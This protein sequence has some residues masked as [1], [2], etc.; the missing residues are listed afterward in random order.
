MEADPLRYE[1]WIE[2]ALRAVIKRALDHAAAHG[3]A[4]EH[5]FYITF[6]T[7]A[8]GLV[9]PGYLRALHPH[10]MTI[11]LQNQ[12]WNLSVTEEGFSVT[13]RFKGRHEKLYIPFDAVTAFADP[14]VNFG[15][16]LKVVDLSLER[17]EEDEAE[18]EADAGAETLGSSDGAGGT[19]PGKVVA[20]D[21]FRKK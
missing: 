17:E 11:V 8:D 12:Y 21:A 13:L 2:D 1:Q 7:A 14:S 5:H 20:L 9:L 3:L 15:L 6:R 10:D 18:A 19:E 16:Q 4:D